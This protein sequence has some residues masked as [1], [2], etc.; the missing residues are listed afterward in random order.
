VR[1]NGGD[2]KTYSAFREN[3]RKQQLLFFAGGLREGR[4]TLEV[5]FTGNR[6]EELAIDYANIYLPRRE[7]VS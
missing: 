5:T 6:N 7:G 3:F 1:L 4:Q 2:F